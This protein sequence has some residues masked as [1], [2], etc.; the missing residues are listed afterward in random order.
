M[1]KRTGHRPHVLAWLLSG[2]LTAVVL[3]PPAAGAES[4]VD[5]SQ[6][7][8]ALAASLL[9]KLCQDIGPHPFGTKAYEQAAIIIQKEMAAAIPGAFLD[10]YL[11][12]WE[13]LTRTP[14]LLFKGK[15]I[16]SVAAANCAGTPMEG[17][18]GI[19]KKT[20][21][22]GQPAF[23]IVDVKTGRAAAVISISKDVGPVAE[24][25]VGRDILSLPRFVIGLRDVPLVELLVKDQAEVQARLAV[26]YAP[27]VPTYNVV[28]T[29]P[30]KNCQEILV[31][32]HAD[33]VIQTEGA[34]DNM[35]SV[36]VML[37]LAHAL[38]GTAPDY[39][40]TF[41]ATG[42]EEGA[43]YA[44]AKHYAKRREA[45]GTARNIRFVINLDSLT[46]GPNIWTSTKDAGLIDLS[47]EVH[48]ALKLKTEPIY[49]PDREAWTM[50]ASPFRDIPG[51][52]AVQFNSRGYNTLA[53]NHTPADNAANV[54]LDCVE[55]GFLFMKEF[56][57][58]LQK[59]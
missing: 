39:T 41:V 35:A 5:T 15:N 48:A 22:Q 28:G 53:A 25:L 17:L 13:L 4:P 59:L 49:S 54:P 58:R 27:E 31:L 33:S 56:I 42:S 37:L 16:E 10:R 12:H 19:I 18:T 3:A 21:G 52:R 9:K 43:G 11:D 44:G 6:K 47:K 8:Q 1:N 36:V 2:L 40:I 46:Y 45:E 51:A 20:D 55:S 32:A 24:Y 23:S 29:I 26:L 34:N 7:R 50:D 14:T 38:S 57:S 30:G